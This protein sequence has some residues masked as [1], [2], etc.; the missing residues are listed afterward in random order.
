MKRPPLRALAAFEA[1]ARLGNFSDAARELAITTS[2]ISHQIKTL[3]AFLGTRLFDR[4]SRGVR[5]T[6]DGATFYASVL[7]A[8]RR[9]DDGT[10]R[11]LDRDAQAVLTVRCGL[12]FGMRWLTPRLP[13]FLAEHPEIDLRIVTPIFHSA[14]READIEILYGDHGRPGHRCVP[15]PAEDIAPMCSPQ[16]LRDGPPLERPAD[17]AK[18]RLIDPLITDLSWARWFALHDVAAAPQ[19]R[20]SFDSILMALQAAVSGLGIALE[21]DF[22]ASEDLASGRLV[23]PP[24]L[25]E[26]RVRR[27]L[28]VLV[29][30]E[31]RWNEPICRSFR[32]WLFRNLERPGLDRG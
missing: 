17:L 9:I 18:F 1:A 3:E 23:V 28:R 32:D 25:R 5:P 30:R 11:I 8:Y 27:S 10:R 6:E 4:L 7:Q 14:G 29:M 12:S 24:A 20:I 2:A 19:A 26:M 16:L 13:L 21:G 31:D 22:L 15:L